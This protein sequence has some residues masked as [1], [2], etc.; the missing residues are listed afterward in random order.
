[1]LVQLISTDSI[2]RVGDDEVNRTLRNVAL[3]SRNAVFVEEQPGIHF[4]LQKPSPVVNFQLAPR[5]KNTSPGGDE[6]PGR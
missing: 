5:Q 3:A 6:K 4:P 2:R 1:M